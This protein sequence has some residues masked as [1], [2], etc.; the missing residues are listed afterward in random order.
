MELDILA[1][2]LDEVDF[3]PA[4]IYLEVAQ[5]VRTILTTQKYS[6]PLDRNFGLNAVMLDKPMPRARAALQAEIYNAIRKYEP[7]CKVLHIGFEADLDGKLVPKVR[8]KI[9]DGEE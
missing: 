5:N 3:A 4:N 7:R 8:I 2:A 1:A 9:R 6:V